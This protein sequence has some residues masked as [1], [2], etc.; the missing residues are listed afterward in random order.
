MGR[1]GLMHGWRIPRLITTS[2]KRRIVPLSA[3]DFT[4]NALDGSFS[5]P[6]SPS[7]PGRWLPDLPAATVAPPAEACGCSDR[8][9]GPEARQGRKLRALQFGAVRFAFVETRFCRSLEDHQP[10]INIKF[11]SVTLARRWVRRA[12]FVPGPAKPPRPPISRESGCSA[13]GGSISRVQE[14]SGSSS[15]GGCVASTPLRTSLPP[16]AMM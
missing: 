13:A 2:P 9:A 6:E 4:S 12:T 8:R 1:I 7:N 3:G 10:L 14:P 16:H 5:E 11:K 15:D